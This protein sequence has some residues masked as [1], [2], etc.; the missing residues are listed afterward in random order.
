MQLNGG[1]LLFIFNYM[2]NGWV[3]ISYMQINIL[4]H[5]QAN[6]S[7]KMNTDVRNLMNYVE[8]L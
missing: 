7:Q 6:K 8:K 5:I 4:L 2:G 3:L 1:I